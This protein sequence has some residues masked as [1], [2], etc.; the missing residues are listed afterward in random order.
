MI[1]RDKVASVLVV[2]VVVISLLLLSHC[3]TEKPDAISF[4]TPSLTPA[5]TVGVTPSLAASAT[6]VASVT[7]SSKV[8]EV[9]KAVLQ[10]YS[11]SLSVGQI[12]QDDL[13]WV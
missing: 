9:I 3:Q 4:A 11:Q 2:I 8:E 6:T 13:Y 1:K 10:N 7:P 5:T 12:T